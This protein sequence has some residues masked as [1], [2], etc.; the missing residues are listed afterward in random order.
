MSSLPERDKDQAWQE[1]LVLGFPPLDEVHSG[2]DTLLSRLLASSDGGMA[3]ALQALVVHTRDHFAQEERWME[4]TQFPA[5]ACHVDEHAAVL[6]SMDGV[7]A[8]IASGEFDA[9]RRLAAAL[10]DWFPGH[11]THL[12]SALAHWMCKRVYGGKPV[13]LRRMARPAG[14]AT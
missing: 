13:V 2:F 11:A 4:E 3:E 7:V 12:D 8:K 14:D 10:V 1:A 9:G 6:A 5:A